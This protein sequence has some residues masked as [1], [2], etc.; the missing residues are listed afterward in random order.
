MGGWVPVGFNEGF[1]WGG[2]KLIH[3]S[4]VEI[5]DADLFGM[6]DSIFLSKQP[7]IGFPGFK[8]IGFQ[9]L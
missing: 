8:I 1:P 5:D 3:H 7:R 6:S 4:S 2:Q 9:G